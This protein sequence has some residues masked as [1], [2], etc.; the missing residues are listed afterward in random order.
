[1]NKRQEAK[2]KT[3]EHI[4]GAAT[5][6]VREKGIMN[7]PTAEIAEAAGVSHGNLFQH[8]ETREGLLGLVLAGE[9]T[10]IARALGESCA[11]APEPRLVLDR[12]LAVLESEAP[13]L[14]RLYAEL[15]LLPPRLQRDAVA[16]EATIRN[17]FFRALMVS[18]PE[19]E[20][21]SLTV[22]LDA[23]FAQVARYLTLPE[24]YGPGD[25]VIRDRGRDLRLLFDLLFP[26]P[27]TGG[28]RRKP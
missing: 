3:R 10:R 2:Q 20:E 26:P 13:F 4:L 16:M 27:R 6:L 25:T 15:P 17:A 11:D 1:M 5:I 8:F 22:G 12:Y 7:L 19:M 21:R 23:F 24:L 28:K 18:N 14:S 9:I